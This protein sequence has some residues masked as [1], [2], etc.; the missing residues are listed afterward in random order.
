[1]Y[2]IGEFAAFGRVSVRML[3]HYDAIGLLRPARVDPHSGY[4]LYDP[5]QLGRLLRIVELR[6]FG[7][8]LDD[9]AT[10]LDAPDQERALRDVLRRRR[11]E[12][13]GSI[14]ADAARLARLDERLSALEGEAPMPQIEYRR[15]DPV[16]VYAASGIAPGGGPEN[17]SPVIDRILPPLK[18]ALE[19]A[20]VEHREP[21]VFWYEPVED[22]DDLRV[23]VSWIAGA[24]PLEGEGWEVVELPEVERAAV[25]TYRGDMAGIG[26]AWNA[27]M[28]EIDSDGAEL[29]GACREVYLQSEPL[30]ESEWVTELQQPV[31]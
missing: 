1:M 26:R 16:T 24:R 18:A 25:T 29:V 10:V 20:G 28:Q 23:W 30:P 12:L 3:R 27:F 19:A 8:S 14:R 22:S 15:I 11:A 31:R 7:C 2:T 13:Q 4:R 9:A 17:V 6:D 21:G 5:S